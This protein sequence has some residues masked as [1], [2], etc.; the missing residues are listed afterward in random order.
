VKRPTESSGESGLFIALGCAR[1]LFG[2]INHLGMVLPLW[3]LATV[4]GRIAS[5]NAGARGPSVVRLMA[6]IYARCRHV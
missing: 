5:F 6:L 1:N 3:L 4:M 2:F